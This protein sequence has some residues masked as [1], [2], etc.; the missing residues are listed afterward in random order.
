VG[1]T[2]RE[3]QLH[4]AGIYRGELT[5]SRSIEDPKR[6]S[7]TL[8]A[9]RLEEQNAFSRRITPCSSPPALS[10]FSLPRSPSAPTR[11]TWESLTPLGRIGSLEDLKGA[12]V[13]FSC[14]ASRFTV[15]TTLTVDGGYSLVSRGWLIGKKLLIR[16]LAM[17]GL[18]YIR[19]TRGEIYM[20]SRASHPGRCFYLC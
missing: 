1:E 8:M 14:D 18:S 7:D 10:S 20:A 9:D 16:G 3:G 2:R 5:F 11:S 15:G 4:R 19:E 12:V 6:R 13:L 17:T